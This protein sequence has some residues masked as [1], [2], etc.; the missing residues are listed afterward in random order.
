VLGAVVPCLV[1]VNGPGAGPRGGG[2]LALRELPV[3]AADCFARKTAMGTF[4]HLSGKALCCGVAQECSVKSV[5]Q[6]AGEIGAGSPGAGMIGPAA[7]WADAGARWKGYL[8]CKAYARKTVESYLG[9]GR[10]FYKW[11][12]LRAEGGVAG[13]DGAMLRDFLEYL[14]GT[15]VVSKTQNQA[16]NAL[17]NFYRHGLGAEVGELG[18]YLRAKTSRRLPNVLTGCRRGDAGPESKGRADVADGGADAGLW[19]AAGGDA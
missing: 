18:E 6:K 12:Q 13:V 17:V 5:A 10:R 14:A 16:L 15:G 3:A 11:L 1:P 4:M 8:A 2:A 9:W 19:A 7:T